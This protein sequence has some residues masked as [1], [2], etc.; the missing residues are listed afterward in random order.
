MISTI[1]GTQTFNAVHPMIRIVAENALFLYELRHMS[2]INT[3]IDDGL[4]FSD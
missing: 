1:T 4:A 2:D 3:F